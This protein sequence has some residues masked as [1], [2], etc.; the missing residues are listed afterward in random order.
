M[1]SFSV[2]L[3]VREKGLLYSY[4]WTHDS[5]MTPKMYIFAVF[6]LIFDFLNYTE[7]EA[8]MS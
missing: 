1:F 3:L 5:P 2:L 4:I 6:L 8:G 7:G